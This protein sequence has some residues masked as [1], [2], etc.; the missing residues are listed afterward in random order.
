MNINAPSFSLVICSLYMVLI[1]EHISEGLESFP[2]LSENHLDF[3]SRLS[4]VGPD[5]KAFTYRALGVLASF[6]SR[7]DG[8]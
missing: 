8:F 2:T 6:L 3:V 7:C 4:L 5:C 1:H